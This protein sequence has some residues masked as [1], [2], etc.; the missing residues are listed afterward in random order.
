MGTIYTVYVT[1]RPRSAVT[2][3][4]RR[5]KGQALAKAKAA[6]KYLNE[7]LNADVRY[8]ATH[9][10]VPVTKLIFANDTRSLRVINNAVGILTEAIASKIQ[11]QPA[12]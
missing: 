4:R 11:F 6:L 9:K 7:C 5:L 3:M 8:A 10:V 2:K 1:A 12:Q